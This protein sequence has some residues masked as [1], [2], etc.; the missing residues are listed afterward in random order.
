MSVKQKH[1]PLHHFSTLL[2]QQNQLNA[3]SDV[4]DHI[5][6]VS[7]RFGNPQ[8]TKSQKVSV[9]VLGNQYSYISMQPFIRNSTDTNIGITN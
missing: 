9:L 5:P 1:D 3:E 2:A 8:Y 4:Q 6:E 7:Q